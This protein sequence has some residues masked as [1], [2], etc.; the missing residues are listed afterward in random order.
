MIAGDGR[1]R[2]QRGHLAAAR[3]D[4]ICESWE[5]VRG[6]GVGG[7]DGF[8]CED[9]STV[10]GDSDAI[11]LSGE[12]CY[13]CEGLE[14]ECTVECG[15]GDEVFQDLRDEFVRPHA[16]RDAS[17]HSALGSRDAETLQ[18]I[19]IC[20]ELHHGRQ[21]RSIAFDCSESALGVLQMVVGVDCTAA[22]L[23]HKL[24][25]DV[26][27][28]D[29]V[30]QSVKVGDLEMADAWIVGMFEKDWLTVAAILYKYQQRNR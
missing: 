27:C 18:P 29:E 21:L 5:E 28:F 7:E 1:R 12:G 10:C 15:A 26:V 23:D 22:F 30:L 13:R 14:I 9:R 8:L 11:F 16:S 19:R 24:A 17:N 4:Q 6:V 2:D 3:D 20:D 25:I